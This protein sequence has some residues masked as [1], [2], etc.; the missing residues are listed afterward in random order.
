M[1]AGRAVSDETTGKPRGNGSRAGGQ[2]GVVTEIQITLGRV[3]KHLAM[4]EIGCPKCDVTT[5]A[6]YV[7]RAQSLRSTGS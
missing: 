7:R 2:R 5:S 1:T 3:A 4:L 6:A